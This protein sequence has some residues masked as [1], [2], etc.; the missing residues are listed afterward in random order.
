MPQERSGSVLV[1]E[2]DPAMRDLLTEEL[3]DAGFTV[4]AAPTAAAGLEL[5][6]VTRFDLIITDL[7]MPE[8]D[9]FDLIRGV[10]QLPEPPHVVMITAFASIETA[11]RAVKLGA[12]DYIAK[13]FEIEELLLVADKALG[14]RA[15]RNKVARLQREVE[16]RYGLANI[17][18]KSSAMRDIVA[19]VQRIAGS[20]ASVLITGESGTGKELIARAIHYNSPR[21]SGP[22]VG[23]N[24]AAVPEGLIESELFGHK[25]GAFTD[26]RADKP[27]LFVEADAG[28]IFLDEIGELALPLQAKLLRV[29]QEH[30]VRP[31]G[32][33]RNQRVDV[34]IV[35]ATNRNLETMLADGSFREDLYYR[36][37]VIHLDLPPL[38]GRPE[39]I[40][41]LAQ[42]V[43]A[44]LGA[45]QIPPRR[46]RLSPEAQHLL[47]AYHWPGNVRELM[48]VLE[49][50][51]ALCQGELIA[52]DDLPPQVREK[53]SADFLGAAV[54]RRMSLADLEREFIERVLEDEG[55]NKTRAA[56]R[57]GLDRKT[58]YRKLDEYAR[59]RGEISAPAPL[60]PPPSGDP[61]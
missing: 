12:Y 46:M 47:L 39:D 40:V 60:A 22:F 2:D 38:R 7:R 4:E 19:L 45:R 36:L 29:L 30:E 59:A 5:A 8:M 37:N 25:R 34:R 50:G 20:T 18:A 13:P 58:L 28:T 56:Q 54:A 24:L 9:G 55:G 33:T 17:I 31:L 41:P 6:R 49:R 10:M 16:E 48:N 57:L 21:A 35:A 27:G 26:A 42:H 51:V 14:E 11:I 44:Q 32:A 15:L 53:R 52:D 23:V 3:S 61:E 43:L 1:V